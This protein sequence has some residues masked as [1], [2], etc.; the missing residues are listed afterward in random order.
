MC[1][2]ALVGLVLVVHHQVHHQS[3][4]LALCQAASQALQAAGAPAVPVLAQ[5][6]FPATA[7]IHPATCQCQALG[8]HLDQKCIVF[9]LS[10]LM[11]RAPS[12]VQAQ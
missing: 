1:V 4:A 12:V 7:H 8:L 5:A 9:A 10:P 2:A 6:Q 3:L 11:S